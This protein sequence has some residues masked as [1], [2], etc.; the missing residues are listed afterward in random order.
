MEEKL[1]LE[2]TRKTA[3]IRTNSK[4]AAWADEEVLSH[5]DLEEGE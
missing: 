5:A 3:F 1:T 4:G 2:R